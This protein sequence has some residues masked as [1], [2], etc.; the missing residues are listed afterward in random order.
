MGSTHPPFESLSTFSQS[1]LEGFEHSRLNLISNL[2]KEFRDLFDEW[3]ELAIDARVARC[4][5][6]GRQTSAAD[7]LS[8]QTASP[9]L[10]SPEFVLRS[11]VRC[12]AD[13]PSPGDSVLRLNSHA[14]RCSKFTKARR[15]NCNCPFV[16]RQFRRTLPP[17]FARSNISR[18]AKCGRLVTD[19]LTC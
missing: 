13:L 17:P 9:V 12:A 7:S 6:E 16:E 3:V 11:L 4:I 2:R 18:V 19:R 5:L 14:N 1:C 15:W 8:D 10:G